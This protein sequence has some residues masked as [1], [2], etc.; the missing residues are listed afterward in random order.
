MKMKSGK[1]TTGY[2][3][4]VDEHAAPFKGSRIGSGG[5]KPAGAPHKAKA[6]RHDRRG[7]KR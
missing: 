3:S 4:G 1:Q 2:L 7:K 6:S 5:G